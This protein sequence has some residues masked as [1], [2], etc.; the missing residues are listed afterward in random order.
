MIAAL[1]CVHILAG[2]VMAAPPPQLAGTSWTLM[3]KGRIS[4]Q[5][6]GSMPVVG[7]LY[8][9][10]DDQGKVFLEDEA[11]YVLEGTYTCDA[12]GRLQITIPPETLRDF[13]YSNLGNF[14]YPY[15]PEM[16]D[17]TFTVQTMTITG[18]VTSGR[19]GTAMTLT[20]NLRA[21]VGFEIDGRTWAGRMTYRISAR[22][23]MDN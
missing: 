13:V 2:L 22:G 3:G 9:S 12:R 10:F 8:L 23:A 4:M 18:R 15:T 20:L 1:A 7:E 11:A 19:R 6:V 21:D 14:I 16:L 17:L 5:R